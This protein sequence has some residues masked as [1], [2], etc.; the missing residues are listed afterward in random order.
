VTDIAGD[1]ARLTAKGVA[2][3]RQPTEA[4]A[5]TLAVFADTCGTLIQLYQPA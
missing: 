5:V 4:G 2:F 3:T 1:F